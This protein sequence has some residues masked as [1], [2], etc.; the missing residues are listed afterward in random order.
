MAPVLCRPTHATGVRVG[1]PQQK[2]RNLHTGGSA[3]D[4][5]VLFASDW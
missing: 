2:W 5:L 1:L 3:H 4:M